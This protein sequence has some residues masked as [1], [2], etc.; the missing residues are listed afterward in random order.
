SES[1]G[2]ISANTW[3]HVAMVFDF[4]SDRTRLY[5]NGSEDSEHTDLY[6]NTFT[7]TGTPTVSD[8][9]GQKLAGG[10]AFNGQID[11]FR[12]YNR[13]LTAAEVTALYNSTGISKANTAHRTALTDGLVAYHTFDGPYLTT[14]AS[15]D[16]SGNGNTGTITGS[17]TPT[18]GILGQAA[19]FEGSFNN[20]L[21]MSSD[22]SLDIL[23]GAFSVSVWAKWNDTDGGKAIYNSASS[24]TGF[25][26]TTD[27][28]TGA[29]Y[30]TYAY[31][32]S[33]TP[34]NIPQL[35]TCGAGTYNDNQWHHIAFTRASDD[36]Q[37]LYVD[38]TSITCLYDDGLGSATNGYYIGYGLGDWQGGI[39]EFRV[40]NRALSTDEV[41]QLYNQA[42]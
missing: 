20:Y 25:L 30:L 33:G 6:D 38:G 19:Y 36:T 9:I 7:Y 10:T 16:L 26:L 35:Y 29:G 15:T 12:I 32:S 11:E 22:S 34:S 42:R 31:A 40:Y 3:T 18:T 14:S 4:A 28:V 21:Q 13:G 39:D 37:T 17:V 8:A 41:T 2:T 5:F 1:T 23:G 24:T 27:S